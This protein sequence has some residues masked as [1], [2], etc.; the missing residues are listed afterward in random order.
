MH[1]DNLF[2]CLLIAI[3][4]FPEVHLSLDL[5]LCFTLVRLL[6]LVSLFSVEMF[7]RI[8]SNLNLVYMVGPDKQK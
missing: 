5:P 7:V 6:H 1:L 8:L 2:F 4:L 3:P